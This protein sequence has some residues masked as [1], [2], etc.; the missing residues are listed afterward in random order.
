MELSPEQIEILSTKKLSYSS[1]KEFRRSPEHFVE[2]VF[3]PKKKT[4]ALT[5]GSLIDKVI[6]N[7][8]GWQD[9]TAILPAGPGLLKDHQ[10]KHPTNKAGKDAARAA[11]EAAKS[12]YDAFIRANK[13][14]LLVTQSEAD[15][16]VYV[17]EKV[18]KNPSSADLLSRITNVQREMTWQDPETGLH[19]IGFSDGDGDEDAM[20][21]KTT[22]DASP[23]KFIQ[24]AIKYDYPFQLGIYSEGYQRT[25]FKFP[26]YWYLT[27][28][29]VAP[30]GIL[31]HK[32]DP[33]W[34]EY[35]KKL[36]RQ[37]LDKMAYCIKENKWNASYEFHT[38]LGY[39][40]LELPGY[41]KK[42]L[43]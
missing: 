1:L 32:V 39:H 34:I 15:K 11:W 21:L 6:L 8:D 10:A 22:K 40:N 26:K 17:A 18:W 20:E 33:D 13:G 41:L 9:T 43:E 35:G 3:G 28:E 16:A 27:V 42:E 31:V 12:E 5:T 24:D 2:Y 36:Y 4:K 37:T 23:R 7:P 30:Y 38:A 14:K 19:M 29:T 25:K